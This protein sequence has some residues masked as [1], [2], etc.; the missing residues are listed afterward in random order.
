MGKYKRVKLNLI[1]GDAVA[2]LLLGMMFMLGGLGGCLAA[3]FIDGESG[4][5]LEEYLNTYLT[6]AQ[7][8][9]ENARVN[10]G[11]VVWDLIRFPLAVLL[12][13]FTALGVVSIP[14]VFCVRGFLLSFS[15]ACFFRLFGWM[16][17]VPA[18]LLFGLPAL[19]WAPSFFVLGMQAMGGACDMLRRGRGEDCN[20]SF[21]RMHYWQR[22]ALCVLMLAACA[23]LEYLAL[24]ALVGKAASVVLSGEM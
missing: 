13:G 14:V 10:L 16:G 8:Q 11:A 2:I 4:V 19:L 24:P 1:S 18:A 17:C 6:L 15:V 5:A 22:C 21:F 23:V 7:A 3:G 20:P 9:G 12:F